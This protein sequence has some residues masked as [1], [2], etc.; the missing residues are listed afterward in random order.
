MRSSL[1]VPCPRCSARVGERC[2]GTD[3]GTS[4]NAR[5]VRWQEQARAAI[6]AQR[7]AGCTCDGLAICAMHVERG[8]REIARIRAEHGWT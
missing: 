6:A 7:E 1:D 4:H 3:K 5:I 2:T 8:R